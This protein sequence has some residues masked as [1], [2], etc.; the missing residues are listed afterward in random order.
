MKKER[1]RMRRRSRAWEGALA[2]WGVHGGEVHGLRHHR[3]GMEPFLH[4]LKNIGI[5]KLIAALRF[6]YIL[7]IV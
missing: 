6:H 5:I 3:Q 1:D 4:A 7:Y 2:V